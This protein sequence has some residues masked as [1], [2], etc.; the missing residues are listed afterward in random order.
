MMKL[1][2]N[3]TSLNVNDEKDKKK[4]SIDKNNSVQ[5]RVF[6]HDRVFI[7][8]IRHGLLFYNY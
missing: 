1:F 5:K 8:E 2:R 6:D 7:H 3:F 4:V